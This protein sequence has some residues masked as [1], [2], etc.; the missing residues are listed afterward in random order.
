MK[1]LALLLLLAMVGL[2]VTGLSKP[3]SAARTWTVIAGGG[4]P[5]IS[6][7]SNAFHPRT[8]E[9]AVGDTVRWQF[10][11]F[12]N[13]AFTG[14]QQPPHLEI[15]EGANHFMNPQV[16]FP[17]GGKTYAGAGYRNSGLPEGDPSKL[18]YALRFTKAGTY[19]YTCIVH[20]SLMSGTV[21][22]NAASMGSPESTLRKGRADQSATIK[23]GQAAWARYRTERRGGTVVVPLIGDLRAGWS[24]LR[25]TPRPLVISAGTTV[26]W[27]MR[28][29]YEI[30]NV[31]F[32]GGAK[33]EEFVLVQPQ[34]QGPPKFLINPKVA[35]PAGGTTY[36]GMGFVNSGVLYPPGA[37]SPLPKSFS[38]TFTKPGRYAYVCNVHVLEGMVSTVIVK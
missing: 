13:V 34:A 29:P 20:G 24:V 2:A 11:G 23:A 38:L 19:P 33:P 22:V 25:F 27:E 21:V 7:V 12:H 17:A 10:Q 1:R 28:D 8:I 5:D 16:V 18:T 30:H 32:P 37:P 9:I 31:A 4:T 3:A 35:T 15:E 14:G 6:V 36:D 26:T